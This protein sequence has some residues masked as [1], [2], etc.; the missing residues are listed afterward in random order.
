MEMHDI[1]N[2]Y[3]KMGTFWSILYSTHL[4]LSYIMQCL[5]NAERFAP[6]VCLPIHLQDHLASTNL[7][8]R[9]SARSAPYVR[10]VPA[11]GGGTHILQSVRG[12]R[13]IFIGFKWF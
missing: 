6:G 13:C 8:L 9:H 3:Y 7:A 5:W 4:R 11:R 1:C 2:V 12:E 10:R